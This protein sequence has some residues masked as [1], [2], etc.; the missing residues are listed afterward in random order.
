MPAN[1]LATAAYS[2]WAG[3]SADRTAS[4]RIGRALHF[5]GDASP[6]ATWRTRPQLATIGSFIALAS[7]RRRPLPGVCDGERLTNIQRRRGSSVN[8]APS[9]SEVSENLVTGELHAKVVLLRSFAAATL[10][11]TWYLIRVALILHKVAT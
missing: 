1:C 8:F 9:P 7:S 11:Q 4:N 2:E 10:R 6:C 3:R 5:K